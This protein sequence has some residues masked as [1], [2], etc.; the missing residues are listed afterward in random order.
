MAAMPAPEVELGDTNVAAAL[1]AP[2]AG[3]AD[4]EVAAAVPASGVVERSWACRGAEQAVH[5]HREAIRPIIRTDNRDA[6]IVLFM[7]IWN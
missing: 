1:P 2:D 4:V 5:R 7:G 3:L 6:C